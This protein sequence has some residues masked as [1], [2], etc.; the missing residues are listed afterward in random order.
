MYAFHNPSSKPFALMFFK[1][2]DIAKVGEGRI[3]C[4]QTRETNL[5]FIMIKAK[6]KTVFY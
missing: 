3:I 5:V 4:Y 2:I 6:V 1:D